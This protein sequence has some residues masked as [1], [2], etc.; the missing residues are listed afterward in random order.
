M[1]V[2]FEWLHKIC[3]VTTF[4][5]APCWCD[6]I[7]TEVKPSNGLDEQCLY[8]LMFVYHMSYLYTC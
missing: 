3:G 7:F 5:V 6:Y 8:L 1:T 4:P 2:I